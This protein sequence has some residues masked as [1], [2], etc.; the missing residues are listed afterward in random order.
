MTA[1]PGGV[2]TIVINQGPG[3]VKVSG[4][5]RTWF[6]TPGM[7]ISVYEDEASFRT[8][9]EHKAMQA[10]YEQEREEMT[11]A[12]RPAVE[13]PVDV[14]SITPGQSYA[15]IPWHEPAKTYEDLLG[16]VADA[17]HETRQ[18]ALRA[19]EAEVAF[20][21]AQARERD[22]LAALRAEQR[23]QIDEA[24]ERAGDASIDPPCDVGY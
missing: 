9:E 19:N 18:A 6:L 1:A 23:R 24:V 7:V 2:P 10:T 12:K 16:E 14:N 8:L 20:R 3:T 11:G 22:A 5:N 17:T 15:E 13:R 21:E 4:K